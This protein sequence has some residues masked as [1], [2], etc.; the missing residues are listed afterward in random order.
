MIVGSFRPFAPVRAADLGP[1]ERGE[2]AGRTREP[3][4]EVVRSALQ[5]P[6]GSGDPE[7]PRS[8][9]ITDSLR[10]DIRV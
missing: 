10:L 3:T 1:S 4:V 5:A 7:I 8:E 9:P 6:G 2:I